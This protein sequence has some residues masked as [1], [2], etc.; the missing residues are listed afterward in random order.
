MSTLDTSQQWTP[1][2]PPSGQGN[3][4]VVSAVEHARTHTHTLAHIDKHDETR[5]TQP[6]CTH[7]H[8]ISRISSRGG[9]ICTCTQVHND[10]ST[11]G[12]RCNAGLVARAPAAVEAT[13]CSPT[14]RKE[15]PGP[16][17]DSTKHETVIKTSVTHQ[18]VTF[19]RAFSQRLTLRTHNHC[20]SCVRLPSRSSQCDKRVD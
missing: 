6:S 12:L 11:I 4:R 16:E 15:Q 13:T 8:H 10:K 7:H 3:A 18:K 5:H 14:W 1:R 19:W 20:Q 2:A 9:G 17:R